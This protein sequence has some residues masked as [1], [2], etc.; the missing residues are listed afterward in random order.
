MIQYHTRRS[1][2]GTQAWAVLACGSVLFL[3]AAAMAEGPRFVQDRFGI[4]AWVDPPADKEMDARYAE[5]AEANFTFIIGGFGA[6]TP[7]N[8]ARQLTLCEKHDLKAIVSMAGLPPERLPTGP[9]C[10]GYL[11]V[12]EPGAAAFAGL[13]KTV[14][15]IRKARPG[16]LA[17][18]NLLPD[19][20]TPA[21]L[22]TSTYDEHLRRAVKEMDVDVLSMDHYPLFLPNADGRDGYCKNLEAMRR[23]SV[24]AGIPFW[25]FFNVMPFGPHSD[26]TEAQIRWQV[27]TSI[28]YGAK[29]VMYFCYWT[30]R[31]AEF[32][33]GGAIITADGRRTR[34]F[35]EAKRINAAVKNLGPTLMKLT[36]TG[37]YRVGPKSDAAVLKGSPVRSVSDG[38]Y[39]VGAFRHADGR[40]AALLTN[41]QFAYSAWP[42][43][44]FDADTA[45]VVEV[46]PTTGKETPVVD[47][48]PD[49]PGLQLSL[50]AGE[51]RLFLLPAATARD[52]DPAAP[53]IVSVRKIWDEGQHNA[54]TDLIRF[55]DKWFC[56]FRE[57][58]AHV[59]GNGKLRVIVSPDGEKW[60]SAALLAE[61]G[62]DLRD[63]KLSITPDGRLMMVAGGSVYKDRKLVSRQPRVA[64][65]TNGATWTTPHRVLAEGDWLWR[66]TW[67]DGKA[68][69]TSYRLV[70]LDKGK[71]SKS[72]EWKLTLYSSPDGIHYEKI[73]DL[74]VPDRPNETTLRFLPDGTMV[75]LVRRETGNQFGW[76]GTSRKPYTQWKWHETKHRLGG[77]NFVVLPD[78]E[79]W[80][81]G[82]GH[83]DGVKTVLAHMDAEHY[84]PVL[85]FPSGGDCSYPGLV[86][87]DGL[88]W[89]SYYSSHEGKTSIYLAK[90]SLTPDAGTAAAARASQTR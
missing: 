78:G 73:A 25:N 71:D 52:A 75:A 39:L 42:T 66:V 18:I 29:G 55:K 88:L 36:S 2:F 51:G 59:G 24:A 63:P 21:Q 1:R 3:V 32:P 61:E 28:A 46:S 19:Y 43:V 67:H 81:A 77:P 33:K 72:Q 40:R 14:D 80:A 6:T 34:H 27:C 64:F 7:E 70:D 11:V 62:I 12:D 48:S 79:M 35:E 84:E 45:G 82:R 22:G 69:G 30:P 38:D 53:Q 56:S 76:I 85:S 20:A 16:K 13:R 15:A 5:L 44:V 17:Y 89:M 57:S 41:Y 9:A 87:H 60:E 49:M 68:Y 4:G 47:D 31:G 8:V 83:V 37:V 50:D 23:E 10:W 65:S 58:R 74:E 90:I 86:W 26:P 54:F